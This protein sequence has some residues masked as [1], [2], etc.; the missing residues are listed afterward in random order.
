MARASKRNKEKKDKQQGQENI[1]A[2]TRA[3]FTVSGKVTGT[4]RENYYKTDVTDKDVEW[5]SLNFGVK[6]SPNQIIF[7]RLFGLEKEVVYLYNNDKKLDK[8]DRLKKVDYEDWA[9]NVEEYEEEGFFPLDLTIALERD[10]KGKVVNVIRTITIDGINDIYEDGLLENDMDVTIRGNITTQTY[11]NR[12]GE[13]VTQTNYE[14]TSIYLTK[15][16]IDFEDEKFV[17]RAKFDAEFIYTDHE[18][19]KKEDKLYIYGLAVGYNGKPTPVTYTITTDESIFID[20]EKE[21]K[22]NIEGAE[23]MIQAIVKD[24]E[25]KYGTLCK[26]HGV[27][28]NRV[29]EVED[30]A[31]SLGGL[32]GKKK[33]TIKNYVRENVILGFD[34]IESEKYTQEDIEQ[35]QDESAFV[36]KE[37]KPKGLTGRKKPKEDEDEV[38][39]IDEDDLPF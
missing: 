2:Q 39:D 24:K 31:P 30:D 3:Y 7:M 4:D 29:E 20:T 23:S 34:S 32:A 12:D 5:A 18:Y 28:V 11:V 13:E 33:E 17:E 16:E 15:Q 6:T 9:D 8:A 25:L 10:E 19:D 35:A 1:L 38:I 26:V 27:L 22:E 36:K 37:E 21:I 14:P